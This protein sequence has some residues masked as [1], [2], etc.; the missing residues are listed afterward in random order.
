MDVGS[1]LITKDQAIAA[2]KKWFYESF[3]GDLLHDMES[4]GLIA[5]AEGFSIT[6][7]ATIELDIE[8][9]VGGQTGGVSYGN[10]CENLCRI[11]ARVSHICFS[12]LF[13]TF[14][15]FGISYE[16]M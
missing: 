11:F 8:A 5:Q 16:E 15:L 1:E 7:I 9:L 10:R 14:W 6:L 12:H 2:M 13:L 3:D 4:H